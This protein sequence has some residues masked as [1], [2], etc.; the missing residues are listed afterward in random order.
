[1]IYA[2]ILKNILVRVQMIKFID[3][4]AGMGGFR[5]GFEQ[6][7]KEMSVSSQCVFS[8]DIK[9]HAVEVYKN[10]FSDHE[11]HGD[12]TKIDASAI[13]DFDV[14]L[15]GFPCQAFSMAGKRNGFGDTRGTMFFEVERILK[16]KRPK[17][18]IL[19]NVEGLI[20]HERPKGAKGIGK[21]LEIMLN[22]LQAL[23]YFVEWRLFDSSKF[24][25]AQSR[26][27]V[28][29]VGTLNGRVDLDNFE[30]KNT[31]VADVLEKGLP[32]L[33]T[34]FTRQL[35]SAVGVNN[36]HGKAVRDKRGGENNIHSWDIGVKGPVSAEQRKLIMT[37]MRVRRYKK[38]AKLKGIT[39]SDGMPLTRDEIASIYPHEQL[40]E[41]LE[42]LCQKGYLK[43][44]HPKDMFK[45]ND[46]ATGRE[47]NYRDYRID[48][49]KGYNI[50]TGKLSFEITQI[51]D[52]MVP[53]PTLVATDINRIA[54]VD[55][56]G[57]R[58]L[59]KIEQKRL[60]GFPDDYILPIKDKHTHDLLGN[61]VPVPVVREVSKRLLS[62]IMNW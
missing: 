11:I 13:P 41:M 44:E 53:A 47:V 23:G 33:D 45:K 28:F 60:F 24:G 27:R 46:E 30:E 52:P 36:L 39:W 55:G 12:I 35:V 18:F 15:A 31:V 50:V 56:Q 38:W 20:I 1:M 14:L 21:T 43:L 62:E 34:P 49:P 51:L 57:I 2:C 9:E 10:N 59:S 5:L 42:D 54:V 19:E 8:S 4:F 48:V 25:L 7:A 3:L 26:K 58:R 32:L 61:T 37:I 22:N 16:A 17:A 29:I 40:T 6:A